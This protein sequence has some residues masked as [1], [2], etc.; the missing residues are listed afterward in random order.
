MSSLC[1]QSFSL[2]SFE[3]YPSRR[4]QPCDCQIQSALEH[5]FGHLRKA[6]KVSTKDSDTQSAD[7]V[8]CTSG[9]D[10]LRRSRF[11]KVLEVTT[12]LL[13]KQKI[14]DPKKNTETQPEA[15]DAYVSKA[16]KPN[17][18][19]IRRAFDKTVELLH[20]KRSNESPKFD[21][22]QPVFDQACTSVEVEP[23]YAGVWCA[24]QP[25][26]PILEDTNIEVFFARG[27]LSLS[28]GGLEDFYN[29]IIRQLDR[30]FT[31]MSQEH[32]AFVE[33]AIRQ[34][35]KTLPASSPSPEP[36]TQTAPEVLSSAVDAETNAVAPPTPAKMEK[37]EYKHSP[38]QL[39]TI[40]HDIADEKLS[41]EMWQR[42][43]RGY[44]AL[45]DSL[46]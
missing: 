33:L 39:W 31:N 7:T 6:R 42:V 28:D 3:A 46:W 24:P 15:V 38:L 14:K 8:I 22:S 43:Q 11:Q 30:A 29:Q 10:H 21:M 2:W 4:A 41:D 18:N 36:E 45:M 19:W 25:S 12:G 34:G 44:L 26:L 20:N 17:R 40:A 27:N 35:V 1:N 13:H 5:I 23:C 37:K 9:K 16:V 32:R